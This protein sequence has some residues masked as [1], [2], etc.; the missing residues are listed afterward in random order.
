M[1][2][3]RALTIV[4][5][6]FILTWSGT[7]SIILT[8]QTLHAINAYKNIHLAQN[9]THLSNEFLIGSNSNSR[10]PMM[11]MTSLDN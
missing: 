10:F 4:I 9:L 7:Y 6:N 8:R 5:K 3:P 1:F 2:D 11:V